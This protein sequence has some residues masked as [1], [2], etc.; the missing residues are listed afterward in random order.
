M[1][2]SVATGSAMLH[3]RRR[4]DR[5]SGMTTLPGYRPNRAR[6]VLEVLRRK[7]TPRIQAAYLRTICDGW[8]TKHRFQGQGACAF[9]CRGG[10]DKLDHYA[11]CTVVSHL[12]ATGLNLHGP[13][14]LDSFFCM[15]D[16]HE[17]VIKAR[18]TGIYALYRLHNGVRHC[19]FT[20]QDYQGAFKRFITEG[21]K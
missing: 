13:S 20:P 5:W 21:L 9:G 1:F 8:C 14:G 11:C 12:F 3:L 6:A 16:G 4:M 18:A 17:E 19:H 15:N 2:K 10:R 7:A